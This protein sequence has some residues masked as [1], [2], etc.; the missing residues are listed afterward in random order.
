MDLGECCLIHSIHAKSRS[1]VVTAAYLM[2]KYSWSLDKIFSFVNSKKPGVEIK[3]VYM[4]QLKELEERLNKIHTFNSGWD[5]AKNEED[6]ILKNTYLNSFPI[7]VSLD[8]NK[9]V[10]SNKRV[11]W[12]EMD[13]K[14]GRFREERKKIVYEGFKE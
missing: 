14:M 5:E 7:E 9:T 12:N 11:S 1:F 13:S 8:G 2:K 6:L 4:K 10:K 3:G